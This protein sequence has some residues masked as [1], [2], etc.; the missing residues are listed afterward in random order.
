MIIITVKALI[1]AEDSQHII[2]GSKRTLNI[3]LLLCSLDRISRHA[4]GA[5]PHIVILPIAITHCSVYS[6]AQATISLVCIGHLPVGR[7][8]NAAVTS[9]LDEGLRLDHALTVGFCGL[10]V[11]R[12]MFRNGPQ[13]EARLRDCGWPAHSPHTEDTLSDGEPR[14]WEERDTVSL[15][16]KGVI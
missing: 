11:C 10:L 8:E 13:A 4:Q 2:F 6:A 9:T 7:C 1:G 5:H 16:G 12:T 15:V 14:P 3:V